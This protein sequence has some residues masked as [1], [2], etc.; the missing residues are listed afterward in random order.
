MYILTL[1]LLLVN[2][3]SALAEETEVYKC[4]TPSKNIVYQPM[5]CSPSTE[6]QNIIKIQKLDARQLEEAQ[7]R[8]KATEAEQQ[9][10]DKAAQEKREAAA[11]QWQEE[12][13][14]REAAAA[15]QE[16]AAARREAAEAKQ[17]AATPYP[18]FIPYPSYGYPSYGHHYG[19]TPL[20]NPSFSPNPTIPK[21]SFSPY[22]SPYPR[23]YMP[24]PVF[25]P[26][27]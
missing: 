8:L 17:Q 23:P 15:R 14:Q 25:P 5:P 18:V 19:Q 27:R 9:A 22:P 16:A 4:S 7:N 12:A 1:L 10:L 11:R 24:A 6:N 21:P 26:P 20:F 3:G 13:P 2:T